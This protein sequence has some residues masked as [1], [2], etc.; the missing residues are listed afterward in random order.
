M[1]AAAVLAR[2]GKF[3]HEK[4]GA[5]GHGCRGLGAVPSGQPYTVAKFKT[6]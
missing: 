3:I 2:G 4:Y 6:Y 5:S 1:L